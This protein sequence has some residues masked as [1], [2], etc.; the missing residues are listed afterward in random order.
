MT[1]DIPTA[2]G[3]V[4]TVRKAR[5]GQGGNVRAAY[6]TVVDRCPRCKQRHG[7]QGFVK[8]AL[9][10]PECGPLWVVAES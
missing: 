5:R 6:K 7:F 4:E 8:G 2:H 3:R 9:A 1:A 10:Y